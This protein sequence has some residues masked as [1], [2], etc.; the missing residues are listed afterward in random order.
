MEQSVIRLEK[1]NIDDIIGL[2]SVQE[3]ML[4]KSLSSKKSMYF[5]EFL[6]LDIEGAI[7]VDFLKESWK[8]VVTLSPIK[9]VKT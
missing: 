8:K 5:N 1:S 9:A 2:S 4:Y 6:Q 7:N 3:S